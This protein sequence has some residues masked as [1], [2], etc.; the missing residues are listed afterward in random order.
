[1]ENEREM[2]EIKERKWD[3]QRDKRMMDRVKSVVEWGV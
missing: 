2:R 3:R 1:M